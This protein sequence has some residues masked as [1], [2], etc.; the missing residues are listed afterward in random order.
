MRMRKMITPTAVV[1]KPAKRKFLSYPHYVFCVLFII[2]VLN[3]LNYSLLTGAA[4]V[5]S[6]ELHLNIADIG[7]LSS[8]FIICFTISVIPLG[9]WSDRAQRKNVIALAVV[10]W[11]IATTVTALASSFIVLFLARMLLGMGEAGYAPASAAM[12]S[13]YFS[14]ARRARVMGWLAVADLIGL[15]LGTTIGGVVAGLYYGAWRVAFLFTSIPGLILI[16][17]A[18]R[19]RE[20]RRNEADEETQSHTTPIPEDVS[21]MEALA[22]VSSSAPKNIV[23][24]FHALLRIKTL[25]VLIV[26]QVFTS[27][28]ITGTVIYL[29]IFLQQRDT[30][31]MSSAAAGLYT[32]VGLVLAGVT[33]VILGGYAADWLGQ[34]LAGARVLVCGLS[35]VLSAPC[36][37]VAIVVAVN[38]HS[39]ALFSLFFAITAVLLNI[40]AGPLAAATL[41]VAP[42][43]LRASAVAISLF[44]SHMLGDAFAPSLLGWLASSFD[45]TGYDFAHNMAGHDLTRAMIYVYPASLLI[46]GII[47][48]VGSRWMKD[49]VTAAQ[50][51]SNGAV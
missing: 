18:W 39:L 25:L 46:A 38:L 51:G 13:D 5:M 14:R 15:L 49:D 1:P 12:I 35:F 24:Q 29:S 42:V 37:F 16:G 36:Y 21:D 43:A 20:P 27:F 40:N 28:V 22:Y 48:I 50:R 47:G 31:G 19:L 32:G 11:S 33:G 30:L 9:I 8:A 41:D 45:P 17:V 44:V 34:R 3:S 4:N 10:V 23:S 6:Q 26:M 7:Y 2:S